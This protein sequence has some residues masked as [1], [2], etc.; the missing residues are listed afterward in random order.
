MSKNKVVTVA[1]RELK[2]GEF[3]TTRA[4]Y[5][6]LR[7]GKMTFS[8]V[9]EELYGDNDEMDYKTKK[10]RTMS[11]LRHLINKRMVVRNPSTYEVN[12]KREVKK[13]G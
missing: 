1:P 5:E 13:D 2:S 3:T 7:C 10:N 6:L 8:E 12:P 11:T 4:V 9:M